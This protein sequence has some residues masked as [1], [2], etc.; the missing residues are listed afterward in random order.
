MST[1]DGDDD[2]VRSRK[3]DKGGNPWVIG[4]TAPLE[5]RVPP[6]RTRYR[7][8]VAVDDALPGSKYPPGVIPQVRVAP[9]RRSQ[10]CVTCLTC[11]RRSRRRGVCVCV[12]V[13]VARCLLRC[14][15]V[16]GVGGGQSRPGCGQQRAAAHSCVEG[17]RAC[18][19]QQAD[20]ADHSDRVDDGDDDAASGWRSLHSDD[21]DHH[22]IA[23][24]LRP[25]AATVDGVA[26]R[27]HRAWHRQTPAAA[28]AD[29]ARLRPA[30]Q[31]AARAGAVVEARHA[32]AVLAP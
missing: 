4:G 19:Q 28:A 13:A 21:R 5:A 32:V 14:A 23:D 6:T 22:R 1:S 25:A 10:C 17:L 30:A 31:S 9:L 3:T 18:T 2:D 8:A 12:G 16:A 29:Q 7:K 26:A 24:V 20:A 11:R 15:G 27:Q